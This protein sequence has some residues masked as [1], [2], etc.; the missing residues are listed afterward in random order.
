MALIPSELKSVIIQAPLVVAPDTRVIDAIAQ[1]SQANL[2]GH[3]GARSC[4]V[5]VDQAQVVGLFTEREVVRLSDQQPTAMN[6][7]TVGQV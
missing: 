6:R 3:P 7:C 1:M 2:P 5:V 4:C